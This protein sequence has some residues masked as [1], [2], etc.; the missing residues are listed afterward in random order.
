MEPV[1]METTQNTIK[2][3]HEES[4]E[5]Y[6]LLLESITDSVQVID[7]DLRYIMVN[8]AFAHFVRMSKEQLIGRKMTDLFPDIEETF[9]FKTYKKVLETGKP[10][11]VSD[12]FIFPDG[13]K[14]W[15]EAR[16]YPYQQNILV[17]VNDIT[18]Y[19]KADMI[20]KQN[21]KKFRSLVELAPDGII[22]LNMRGVITSINSAFSNL[23]GFPENEIIGKHFLKLKTL[24]V[25]D[26]AKYLKLFSSFI[27]G[28]KKVKYE[29][30]YIRKD[31]TQCLGEAHASLLKENGKNIG[32]ISIL[33]D[34][35]ERKKT[36]EELQKLAL[37]VKHSS[38]LITLTTLDGKIIFLNE[39][40]SKML[41]IAPDEIEKH[42]ILEIIPDNLKKR[43]INE[44]IPALMNKGS[45]EG[46]YKY[47][48]IK[49]GKL[50]DVYATCFTINDVH[51]GKPLY[52]ANVSHDITEQKRMAEEL[53]RKENLKMMG[54]LAGGVGH[55]LRNSLGV[56]KNASYFLNM[57][58]K[59]L[60][61]DAKETLEIL[62]NEVATS[63]KIIRT[64]LDF[65]RPKPPTKHKIPIHEIINKALSRVNIPKN[66]E[67]M[68]Q[69]DAKSPMIVADPDQLGQVFTNLIINAVQA[70]PDGGQLTINSKINRK[71][72]ETS[73]TDTGVG[74]SVEN[75]TNLFKPLF[76][77]KAKGIGLGL[78]IIKTLVDGH[79]GTIQVQSQVGMGSTFTV[80]IPTGK[81]M[82]N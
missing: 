34:I 21:E 56:I 71:W 27:F 28:K 14:T 63:E 73:I 9:F 23:T 46:E 48:N 70:M 66:I 68:N 2:S 37:V 24:R 1:I 11:T 41:G 47:Q 38:E 13:R 35:T 67:V 39:A 3:L 7:P 20:L 52:L 50:I 81:N 54:M 33:R 76:T 18:E 65:A 51:L 5:Q 17:I 75:L 26:L 62:E 30:I 36:Q 79:R 10:T 32:F 59:D 29:F 22:T 61:P 8:S 82:V 12:E 74:I 72:V 53:R 40:G 4:D 49:T 44:V 64:L 6:Y 77:T 58:L 16:V 45:W 19:K 25:R 43:T 60:E 57:I 55:E 69:V 15:Y 31:G 78:A 80:K 42:T